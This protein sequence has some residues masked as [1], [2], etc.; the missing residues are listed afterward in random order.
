[1]TKSPKE[2]ARLALFTAKQ[3][4][5]PLYSSPSS[6]HDFTQPQLF[7]ILVLQAFFQLDDRGIVALLEDWE[8]MKA[9]LGLKKVPHASTL[10]VARS[11]LLKKGLLTYSSEPFLLWPE[12]SAS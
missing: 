3:G 5:L 2:L 12:D 1:M 10:C 8:D 6:R 7:A 11:R 9:E 4:K